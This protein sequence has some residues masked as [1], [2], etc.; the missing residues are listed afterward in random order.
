MSVLETSKLK[1]GE[2][3]SSRLEETLPTLSLEEKDELVH[4]YHPDY[5]KEAYGTIRIGVNKGDQTVHRVVKLLEG[6]SPIASESI[7]LK[8]QQQVDVL[9]IG[10]GGAGA[11]AALSAKAAGASVLMATKLRL[12]DSNTVM[13]EGGMQVA[14]SPE[15]S[16]VRHFLDSLRGGHMV[17]DKTLLKTLVEEGPSVAKWLIDNGVMFDREDDGNLSLRPGGGS[18]K[19]RLIRCKDYTGLELMRVLKDCVLNEKIEIVEYMPVLELLTDEERACSGAILKNLDNNQ[20]LVVQAKTVIMA[21]GGIGRL[22]IQSFPTSN[23]YGATGDGL[24]LSYRAGAKLTL[25]DTFQYHPTGAIFPEAMAGILVTE[26]IRSVG[27]HLVNVNG[28]RF[29]GEME[30]RDAVASAVIRECQEGRGVETPSGRLGGWRDMPLVDTLNGAGTLDER[31]PNMVKHFS[32]YDIDIS[33]EPVLIYPTLHYQNG[34]VKVD[35][36]GES[37]VKNLFVAGEASGGLHGRNR[38]MGNSLLDIIVYGKRAGEAAAM[39]ATET[40]FKSITLQH[41]D[42][43]HEAQ[44]E[45][46]VIPKTVSP[47]LFPDYVNKN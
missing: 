25:Q 47:I 24:P 32:R 39:R 23:H 19:A 44:K 12:G 9:I 27:A 31:F 34:G 41:L 38:L 7:Q 5:K 26:A 42:R 8:A 37:T 4:Q 2:T 17:N 22:H 40:E 29:I 36:D 13:A 6:E 46:G 1:V 16:P 30:T 35:V 11:M 18:S 10:G 28:D 45:A 43:F 21:T 33:K 20:T 14:V 15:D 3:R